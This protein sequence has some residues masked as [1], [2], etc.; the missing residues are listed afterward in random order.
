MTHVVMCRFLR[1]GC[2]E[3]E[4]P[5]FRR[6]YA[7]SNREKG[8]KLLR[9]FPHCCPE[10]VKRSYCGCSVHLL[11]TFS[12]DVSDA[13]AALDEVVVATR[14]EP[15]Q[16]APLWPASLAGLFRDVGAAGDDD[17]SRHD[18]E[19]KLGIGETV[20]LP[21]SL[22]GLDAALPSNKGA[23]WNTVL[24]AINK[25]RFPK[26]FYNYHGS[27]TRTQREMTHH[28]V[29]YVFHR[30]TP[31]QS[32]TQN[33]GDPPT[34]VVLARHASPAFKLVSFRRSGV[35]SNDACCE[36]PAMNTPPQMFDLSRAAHQ[37]QQYQ[38]QRQQRVHDEPQWYQQPNPREDPKYPSDVIRER[39]AYDN[40]EEKRNLGIP[41]VHGILGVDPRSCTREL[42]YREKGQHLLILWQFVKYISLDD[43]GIRAD[44]VGSYLMR[45]AAARS[46]VDLEH[47]AASSLSEIFDRA[48]SN[49][50]QSPLP[51]F[52]KAS[53]PSA[54]APSPDPECAVIR[55][56]VRLFLRGLS[57]WTVKE[58]LC[59]AFGMGSASTSKEKLREQFTLLVN[60]LYDVLDDTLREFARDDSGSTF[61][62]QDVCLP[63]LADA[64]LSLVS[65]RVT[66]TPLPDMV[67]QERTA[68]RIDRSAA[69]P[70]PFCGRWV[71]DPQSMHAINV[72]SDRVHDA[73][74]S[75]QMTD[76]AQFIR[77]V[78]CIDIEVNVSVPR[79]SVQSVH[80]FATGASKTASS[81]LLDGRL[82]VFRVLPSGLSSMIATA[83]G[84]SIGDYAG[85]L[86]D[87]AQS[88][89]VD[90]FAF[91]E[92]YHPQSGGE[93]TVAR[94]VSMTLTLGQEYGE[95]GSV[96]TRG[97]GERETSILVHGVVYGSALKPDTEALNP[98]AG[99]PI[100]ARRLSTASCADRSAV[101]SDLRWTPLIE[102]QADYVAVAHA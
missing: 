63:A 81:M 35:T 71:L 54:T 26:W 20:E 12:A 49:R 70:N 28:L 92:G 15:S 94:R 56:V 36:L 65:S 3:G 57:S 62:N 73:R 58:L 19:R 6:E 78:G 101:W 11:V 48:H 44:T 68:R 61:G 47:I 66:A 50:D 23:I 42:G 4:H 18:N 7:R 5:L 29:A 72:A 60:S 76:A 41:F 99:D 24:Y 90:F 27:T 74:G 97:G 40:N 82:R 102:M 51:I 45:T 32:T 75:F 53:P 79:L 80:S 93:I 67:L 1:L 46:D 77:E 59:T 55:V 91:A 21:A 87:D 86:S 2:S 89:S 84:W 95:A 34:A 10:H 38:Q 31:G 83:G 22:F 37:Q 52:G 96:S 33:D 64:V 85:A 69:L 14:F 98:D 30:S 39:Y 25:R 9:C 43:I 8:V 17:R 13:N 88:L 16:V 100:S